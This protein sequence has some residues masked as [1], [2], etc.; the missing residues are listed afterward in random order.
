MKSKHIS[1]KIMY[2]MSFSDGD[3]GHIHPEIIH[4]GKKKDKEKTINLL[5]RLVRR[6][7]L[8]KVYPELYVRATPANK[9]MYRNRCK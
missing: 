8:L 3:F 9:I 6:G 4:R 7:V 2:Y 1:D 5:N